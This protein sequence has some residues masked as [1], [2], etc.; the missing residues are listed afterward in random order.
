MMYIAVHQTQVDYI[1]QDE[2][3]PQPQ[4]LNTGASFRFTSFFLRTS[5]KEIELETL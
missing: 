4:N 1:E 3:D 2:R 5:L